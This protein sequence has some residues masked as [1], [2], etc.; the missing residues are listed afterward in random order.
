MTANKNPQKNREGFQKILK[1]GGKFYLGGHNIPELDVINGSLLG[2][3]FMKLFEVGTH[4]TLYFLATLTWEGR[5]EIRQEQVGNV[6]FT[7]NKMV[8]SD[9]PA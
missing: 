8:E 3:A 1:G 7:N 5:E 2:W 4:S 6:G 9:W